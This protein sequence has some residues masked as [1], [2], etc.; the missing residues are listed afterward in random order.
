MIFGKTI[1]EKRSKPAS[2]IVIA[3]N[4]NSLQQGQLKM[5]KSVM[6]TKDTTSRNTIK[7]IKSSDAARVKKT[8]RFTKLFENDM[9]KM[10]GDRGR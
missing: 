6:R 5:P 7:V 3:M 2:L 1:L 4:I 10:K 8:T 9:K